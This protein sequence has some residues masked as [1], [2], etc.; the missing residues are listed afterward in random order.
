MREG[1]ARSIIEDKLGLL[2][3]AIT[4]IKAQESVN[5]VD[6]EIDMGLQY[7]DFEET[8]VLCACSST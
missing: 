8:F 3:I 7:K 4:E 2:A 1:E 6:T 5:L